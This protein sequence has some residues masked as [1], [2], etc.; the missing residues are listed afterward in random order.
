MNVT[1]DDMIHDLFLV[2]LDDYNQDY[3]QL[4]LD[5][6]FANSRQGRVENM[7]I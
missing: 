2:M 7:D 3:I 5:S 1:F 4:Q 6:H